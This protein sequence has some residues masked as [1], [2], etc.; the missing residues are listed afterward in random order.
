MGLAPNIAAP[1]AR[2]LAA[3]AWQGLICDRY[4]IEE[5]DTLLHPRIPD[6]PREPQA[7]AEALKEET[8][9]WER[10]ILALTPEELAAP[11]RQ[12]N[13]SPM[14]VRD[15][16]CHMIQ[17]CIY[18]NG[19]FATLYF[20]LGLDGAEPYDCPFPN[21]L[22]ESLHQAERVRA[23]R[24]GESVEDFRRAFADEPDISPAIV[25]NAYALLSTRFARGIPVRASDTLESVFLLT[26]PKNILDM[27]G[28][29]PTQW[30]IAEIAE[31][32]G[33]HAPDANLPAPEIVTVADL[34]RIVAALD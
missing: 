24:A 18:K 8:V 4:H 34:V 27:Y 20:A 1:T 23:E 9:L 29:V 19:Q 12:F 28:G 25:E 32:S 3:H 13:N 22:Y 15:F 31:K 21:P 11:R 30:L 33:K 14:T 2:I 16:V 6:P 17:N 26:S 10:M 5:P 7:M